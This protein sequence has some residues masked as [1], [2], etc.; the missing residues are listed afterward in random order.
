MSAA[1]SSSRLADRY[2]AWAVVTGASAGIG[3]AFAEQLG[4]QGLKL[5]LVARR[6]ERL[7]ALALELQQRHGCETRIVAA[8]LATAEGLQHV[9]QA[10]AGLDVGLLV[11]AAGFGTSGAF[12]SAE[13]ATETEMLDLN[14]RAL[15]RQSLHF[16]RRF[17]ERRRGALILLGSLVGFQGTPWAAHYAATKAYVQTLAEGLDLELRRSGVRVL[18]VAPGPVHTEFAERAG[19][20]M[21]AALRPETVARASLRALGRK[22]TVWPGFLSWFLLASLAPLP[23]FM[24]T[25]IM[26]LVMGGM[27]GAR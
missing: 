4:T 3:R 23:R 20:T 6:R 14:C 18:A 5:V 24:R 10:C 16:G 2:G 1:A 19:L 8:D 27:A 13:L 26:G 12:V 15:L 7:E 25:R 22:T 11:A 21:G 9:E 17:A